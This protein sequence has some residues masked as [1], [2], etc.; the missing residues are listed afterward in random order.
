VIKLDWRDGDSTPLASFDLAR[1]AASNLDWY[2][3]AVSIEELSVSNLQSNLTIDAN[4]NQ[5]LLGLVLSSAAAA[6]QPAGGSP[7]TVSASTETLAS[8]A[9]V[10]KAL[11]TMVLGKLDLNIG[12]FTVRDQRRPGSAPI[13][14]VDLEVKNTAPITLGGPYPESQPMA[15][16]LITGTLDPVVKQFKLTIDA[17]PLAPEPVATI[18]ITA[19]GIQGK[20]VTDLFPGLSNQLDGSG[21][22]DGRF[23]AWAQVHAKFDRRG[24]RDFD[25]TRPFDLDFSAKEIAF[26]DHDVGRVLAGVDQVTAESVHVEPRTSN[27]R[28]KSLEITTPI[29][30]ALRDPAGIHALGMLVPLPGKPTTAPSTPAIAPAKES[31]AS[32]ALPATIA[33]SSTPTGEI[34]IDRLLING[35]DIRLEDK[36]VDPPL[37]VPLK[38]M[39]IEIRDFSTAAL[40]EDRPIRFNAVLEADKVTLPKRSSGNSGNSATTDETESRELFSQVTSSGSISLYPTIHG[41]A[42]TAINGVELAAFKGEAG[43]LG[44]DLDSG[45]FDADINTR[46]RDEGSLDVRSKFVLTHLGLSAPLDV[47]LIALRDP[48]GGITIPLN[49]PLEKGKLSTGEVIGAATGAL[50]QIMVTAVASAPMKAASGVTDMLRIGGEAKP[51][52]PKIVQVDFSP[53]DATLSPDGQRQI[54]DVIQVMRKDKNAQATIRGELSA[55]DVAVANERANPT[56][57]DARALADKL[58]LERAQLAADRQALAAK[59]TAELTSSSDASKQSLMELS[60]LNRRIDATDDAMDQLYDMLRP[61][62]ANQA[63]RRA[64]AASLKIAE[65]RLKVIDDALLAANLPE[66][67]DRIEK[68]AA[69]DKLAD[70]GGDGAVTITVVQRKRQQ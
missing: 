49:I 15:H 3:D 11:P 44:V 59:A 50:V 8:A 61:G 25:P 6:T 33:S 54:D 48:D 35:S 7:N 51:T 62:A 67:A 12:R 9:D 40:H 19:S 52:E 38:S 29:G 2:G 47:V 24:P 36:S 34:R 42:K 23:H 58:R 41:Y 57:A 64:R 30:Y 31:V 17:A 65:L 70:A 56:P 10:S 55:D 69:T 39:D 60:D 21:M 4:G 37:V 5:H 28:I 16:L 14:V 20:G 22:I 45:I 53:G 63:A 66:A 13:E 26:R 68:T 43:A 32:A 46:F 1:V 18:E 27:V